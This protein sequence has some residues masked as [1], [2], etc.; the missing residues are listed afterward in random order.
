MI[1]LL[2]LAY[3]CVAPL[4]APFCLLYFVLATLAQKYQLIVRDMIRYI[5][6]DLILCGCGPRARC[7]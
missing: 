6:S 2:G 1:I 4:I 7:L 3:C 5:S